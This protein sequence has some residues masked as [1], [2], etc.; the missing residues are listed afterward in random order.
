MD[1]AANVV[2]QFTQSAPYW[3]KY[4]D[5]IR[6]MFAPV[7]EAL[8][9]DAGIDHH[10]RVLDVATGPGE[11][12]LLI[13]GLVGTN[14]NVEGI[15]VVPEMIAAAQREAE[16]A[17]YKNTHFQIASADSLPF[18]ENAFD[19]VVS[20]FGV[21]F[22]PSPAAGVRE[23]LRVLKPGYKLSMAV[24]S[25]AEQNAFHYV[26]SRV[27]EKYIPTPPPEPGAPDAFL[28]AAPGK[29][30]NI[31]D[32]AGAGVSTDRRLE[33]R[34]EIPLS[35]DDFWTMRSGMSD[36]LR[37][38]LAQLPAEQFAAVRREVM[39]QLQTYS[40]DRGLSLPAEVRIVSA[41]K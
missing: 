1:P 30:K 26:F 11:P 28:F 13:A 12:A 2:N 32:E 7:T 20:R 3:E 35:I 34:I 21:M 33:F 37:A 25:Y 41:T 9:E 36:R 18:T 4:R 6:T 23:M 27:T 29:L 22:F 8:I 19:A 5:V 14:G 15:D 40:T 39:D 38:K 17:G 24:W 31:L 10:Y 16:R